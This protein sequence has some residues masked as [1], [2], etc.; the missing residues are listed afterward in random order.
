MYDSY[1][2]SNWSGYHPPYQQDY[3]RGM[4]AGPRGI[5]MALENIIQMLYSWTQMIDGTYYTWTTSVSMALSLW[6]RLADLLSKCKGLF[7]AVIK[8]W[9]RIVKGK[10]S[11]AFYSWVEKSM[12]SRE[13]NREQSRISSGAMGI[14]GVIVILTTLAISYIQ[15]KNTFPDD[16]DATDESIVDNSFV[17]VS[18]PL[19]AKVIH[20]FNSEN[21]D[22][23]KNLEEGQLIAITQ[24]PESHVIKNSE[25]SKLN[26]HSQLLH[27]QPTWLYGRTRAGEY[28]LFPSNF[29][30][31]I[32]TQSFA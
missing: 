4:T 3:T 28:G 18:P 7:L 9:I 20:A 26:L 25:G 17:K 27:S 29:I 5:S 14:I 19:F 30:S 23:I 22:D 6:D 16:H 15:R 21:P 13:S 31:I 1:S 32:D 11:S 10:R 24:V 8:W 2:G 12:D